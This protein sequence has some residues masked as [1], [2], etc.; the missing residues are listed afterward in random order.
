MQF[1]CLAKLTWEHDVCSLRPTI[2]VLMHHLLFANTT[3]SATCTHSLPT[4]SL[5]KTNLTKP[6]NKS[7]TVQWNLKVWPLK[8]KFSMGGVH[9]AAELS[10]CFCK[11]HINLACVH[12]PLTLSRLGREDGCVQANINPFTPKSDQLQFSLSA[13]HKRYIIQYGNR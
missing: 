2:T 3:L 5:P 7:W 13:S 1:L 6:S 12:P 10:S 11:F 4:L 8:W 9:I